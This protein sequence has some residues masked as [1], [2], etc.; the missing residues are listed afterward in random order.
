MDS[1]FNFSIA[2]IPL[3]DLTPARTFVRLFALEQEL[4]GAGS[5][6][7]VQC[8]HMRQGLGMSGGG[9]G[10]RFEN[11]HAELA[12]LMLLCKGLTPDQMDICRRRYGAIGTVF[13]RERVVPDGEIQRR[14]LDGQLPAMLTTDGE[15]PVRKATDPQTGAVIPDHTVVRGPQSMWPTFQRIAEERGGISSRQV[16]RILDDASSAVRAA[17]T[18]MKFRRMMNSIEEGNE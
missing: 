10:S 3:S 6:T 9:G 11:A 12:S 7:G 2:G 18:A 14:E 16:R 15:E 17:I 5:I 1:R 13:W 4:S 8:E